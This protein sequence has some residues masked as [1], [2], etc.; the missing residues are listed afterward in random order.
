MAKQSA[1]AK[2]LKSASDWQKAPEVLL[3][4]IAIVGRSNAGKSSFLNQLFG[5]SLAKVSGTPG[6]TRLLNFYEFHKKCLLVDLPGYGF[7]SRS[8]AE[9]RSWQIMIEDYLKNR[10]TLIGLVLIMDVRRS[11]S[12]DEKLLI[13]FAQNFGLRACLVL[14]KIDKISR[15]KTLQAVASITRT[16]MALKVFSISSLNGAGVKE[17]ESFLLKRWVIG[18]VEKI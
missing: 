18:A 7:A 4:E 2:F 5:G 1:K 14:T 15:S 17:V 16:Q 8:K 10:P 6:K 12:L 13:D 11:F 3:P 9:T